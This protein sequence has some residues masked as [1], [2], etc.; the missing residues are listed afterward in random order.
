MGLLRKGSYFYVIDAFIASTI[1][2]AAIVILFSQFLAQASATQA[3][4]TADDFLATLD[5]TQVRSYDSAQLRQWTTDGTISNNKLSMLEQMA[6]FYAKLDTPK[7]QAMATMTGQNTPEHVGIE[8]VAI[9]PGSR[10]QLYLRAPRPQDT[11]ET[12]LTAKRIIILQKNPADLYPP[13][14][15]E[16]RTWQ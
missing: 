1:I 13:V 14:I 5:S 3:L 15:I 6:L 4:Y 16:V 12:L 11:A 2:I 7:A 8:I 10:T 9:M